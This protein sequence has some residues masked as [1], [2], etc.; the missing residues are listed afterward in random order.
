MPSTLPSA[1]YIFMC[2]SEGLFPVEE[3]FEVQKVSSRVYNSSEYHR[4]LNAFGDCVVFLTGESFL[5]EQGLPSSM[6]RHVV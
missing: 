2:S 3:P 4:G 5:A 6:A 1:S